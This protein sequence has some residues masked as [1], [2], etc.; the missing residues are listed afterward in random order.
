MPHV[1]QVPL[2]DAPEGK[3]AWKKMREFLAAHLAE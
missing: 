1:F 2:C 3:A